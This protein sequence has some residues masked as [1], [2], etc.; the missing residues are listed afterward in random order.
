MQATST[1][2]NI[3]AYKF[4][5][6]DDTAEKRPEFLAKCNELSLKGTILLLS[7]IHI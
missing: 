5:T 2:V 4:I 7:L 1:F 3:A 6:F